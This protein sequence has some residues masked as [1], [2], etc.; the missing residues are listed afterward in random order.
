M[1]KFDLQRSTEKRP[2][3]V[4][5]PEVFEN[6]PLEV[7]VFRTSRGNLKL[8]EKNISEITNA[9]AKTTLSAI[10]IAKTI[11]S[12]EYDIRRIQETTEGEIR[13]I[14][15]DID[16][17]IQ[18]ANAQLRIMDQQNKDWHSQFDKK[19]ELIAYLL[20]QLS[21]H[22]EYSDEVKKQIIQLGVSNS[23]EK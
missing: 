7:N 5:V 9:A 10:E 8:S 11:V 23:E 16:R 14:E 13:K 17:I 18:N 22:P 15:K 2:S 6:K 20:D 4:I 12:G 21:Q 3:E 19:K 1:S